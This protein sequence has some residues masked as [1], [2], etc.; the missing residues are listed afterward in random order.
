MGPARAATPF[1]VASLTEEE[2][3]AEFAYYRFIENDGI[4]FCSDC[5]SEALIEY[6]CRPILKCKDCGFKFSLTSGTD[7]AYRKLS[8]KKILCIITQFVVAYQGCSAREIR[9][10]IRSIGNYKTAWVWAHKVR[11]A[12]RRKESSITLG[13]EVEVDGA[14]VGGYVRPKN[15][16]K[17][18]QDARKIFNRDSFRKMHVV[19]ARERGGPARAWI[20]KEEEQAVSRIMN[21]LRPGTRVITDAGKWADFREKFELRQVP[22]KVTYYTPEACTNLVESGFRVLRG[23][24]SIHRHIASTYLDF[25]ASELAWRLDRT[26]PDVEARLKS[27]MSAML[28][29]GRSP[30]TGY[31]LKAKHGGKKRL[32]HVVNPDG[33]DGFWRPPTREERSERRRAKGI[34]DPPRE[35]ATLREARSKAA[36]DKGF[37]FLSAADVIAE[38]GLLPSE[39][40]IYAFFFADGASILSSSGYVADKRLV[41]WAHGARQHLYTGETYSLKARILQHLTGGIADSNLR[42][43]LFA[44]QWAAGAIPKDLLDPHSRL[45]SEDALSA[46][47]Q[48]NVTIGVKVCHYVGEAERAL[49]ART[50][51]PLNIRDREPLPNARLLKAMRKRLRDEVLT[52][53]E[54]SPQ[55]SPQPRRR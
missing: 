20:A 25:Y 50:A 21:E 30:M 29:G 34:V 31:F 53:W 6:K 55:P 4:P 42:E 23:M 32:C 51:S 9:R 39:P 28:V 54:P 33:A 46:W 52:H 17:E 22:H 2:A 40:G 49:L 24:E 41:V 15:T 3:R 11:A 19:L 16:K 14:Q 26:L 27:V 12:L 8:Y 18:R 13:G 47:L 37:K 5:G 35:T 48:E 43:T 45:R 1:E 36:W 7:F 44:L 38:P 10:N